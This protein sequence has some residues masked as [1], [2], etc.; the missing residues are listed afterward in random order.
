MKTERP[1]TE[2]AVYAVR[3]VADIMRKPVETATPTT[4]VSEARR[5]LRNGWIRH[6]PVL[7]GELLVGMVSDRNLREA[8]GDSLPLREIMTRPVFILSPATP[9]K[10]A[11]RLFRDRRF[12]AAPV[13]DGRRLIGIVSIVDIVGALAERA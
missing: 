8:P 4:T 1:S 2:K 7:D 13:L 3:T 9:L 11:A 5:L 12:G 6:L 10:R